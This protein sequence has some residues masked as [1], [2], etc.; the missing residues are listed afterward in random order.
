MPGPGL[1]VADAGVRSGGQSGAN[2]QG[3]GA[4]SAR[5]SDNVSSSGWGDA[6][7]QSASAESSGEA[8]LSGVER[9]SRLADPPLGL[10]GIDHDWLKTESIEAGMGPADGG[11]PG[12]ESGRSSENL[13]Y[14]A[15][16]VNDHSGESSKEGARCEPVPNV[17]ANCVNKELEL[18]KELGRW[19][20]SNNCNTFVN[21]V[22]EKC[23]IQDGE[24]GSPGSA[25]PDSSDGNGCDPT[26]QSCPPS[27]S[28]PNSDGSCDPASQSCPPTENS[29]AGASDGSTG[30][31][32]LCGP[33]QPN[34][35]GQQP[36]DSDGSACDTT[37]QSC[38]PTESS[39][40][41][42]GEGGSS[43]G[44]SADGPMCGPDQPSD[45]G[46]QSGGNGT[47]GE[48]TSADGPMCGPDQPNDLGDTPSGGIH[49]GA[50][51]GGDSDC[52]VEQGPIGSVTECGPG[53]V[54]YSSPTGAESSSSDST[55]GEDSSGVGFD[56]S[57]SSSSDS[58]SSSASAASSV[59]D[60]SA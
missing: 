27:E 17:D 59:S 30:E 48:G 21:D 53:S 46:F 22:L 32:G 1:G 6:G 60:A 57:G 47:S 5:S 4:W 34:E 18:G 12:V 33:G 49:E 45:S 24:E 23:E 8:S 42:A 55:V 56:S 29:S 44:Q 38:L 15:T 40:A 50:G 52:T 3:D 36:G 14:S 20:P 31:G 41:G 10:V 2:S 37:S 43:D 54:E 19:S 35:S 51:Q 58:S 9:C 25:M 39:S 28:G 13:P 7:S 26:S 16:T 11:V